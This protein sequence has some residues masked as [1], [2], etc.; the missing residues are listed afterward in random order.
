MSI[1]KGLKARARSMFRPGD[2]EAR[3]E[4]EF[5]F[6][7]ETQ[8][9]HLIREGVPPAEARRRALIAFGAVESH[10]ET[11]R[12]ERG[13]RWFD[14]LQADLRYAVGAMRRNPG[15][16]LAVSLTL[17]LGIGV[18]GI[19]F[20]YINSL[21][22]RPVPARAPE[23][24]AALFTRDTRT[25]NV[26]QFGYD[27]FI[28]FRERSGAFAGA[29]AIVAAPVNLVVPQAAGN[30]AG[31]LVWAEI[32]SE[33][34]FSVLGTRPAI[35]RFFTA[36]D[37]PQGANPFVVLS[38][39][40]WQRR[41]QGDPNVAGRTIRINGGEFVVTGVAPRGFKGMRQLGFWPEVWV[42]IGMQPLVRPGATGLLHGRG[43]GALLVVGRLQPGVDLERAQTLATDFAR[44][45]ETAYPATNTNVGVSVLPAR[46]GFENPAI[47]A[48]N[49]LVLSSALGIVG[50]LTVLLIICAN[51][52]VLQLSRTASRAREIAI[53]LSLGCSRGRLTRQLLIESLVVAAPGVALGAAA[54]RLA[55]PLE[56]YFTPKLPFQVGFGATA[57]ARVMFFTGAIAV[58]A[59]VSFGMVPAVRAGRARLIA[60][61]ASGL[62]PAR[63]EANRPSRTR[64]VLVVSQ[65]ALSVILLIAA[66]LFVRSLAMAD[67][68]NLGFEPGNR[69]MVSINVGVQGYDQSRGLQVY[70]EVLRRTR[71]LPGVVAASLAYPAPFDTNGRG[72]RLYV[73]GLANSSD[74]TVA[75]QATYVADTFIPALGVRLQSGRDFTPEDGAAAPPVMIVS[76]SLAGRMWPGK[77]A[78]GQRA[79]YGSVSGPEI[80]VVGVVGDAK[81]AML[82]DVTPRRVYL[83]L[84]QRYPDWQTLV[85]H[86]RDTPASTLSSLREVI[87]GVDPSLPPFGAMTMEQAVAN[88]FAPSRSGVAVAS[89]FGLLALLIASIGLYAVVARSVVERTGEMGVRIALGL[90]PRDVLAHLMRDGARL[91]LIGLAIGV[92]GGLALGRTMAGVLLGLSPADPITFIVVPSAVTIVIIV[93]TFVPARRASQLDAVAALKSE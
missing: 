71:L 87:A 64:S 55:S 54:M 20:G 14:D 81:F 77:S 40:A 85:V 72:V 43:G 33:D 17:G 58:A 12:D 56:S 22:F 5:Q 6:H 47:I 7:I 28:D 36:A 70:D 74:G 90:T 51:L 31:D 84:K 3:L 18:N 88:G 26:G 27:D 42:P 4:E 24:L 9:E 61:A 57:D 93:A 16:T 1:W 19:I 35:G 79:R 38:H 2:A 69:V 92:A 29:A 82:G 34:Y 68:V 83:P 63:S 78:V 30:A 25:G 23:E 76:E 86:T 39:D 66:S 13:A 65:I 59:L 75:A 53:R 67:S 50:S 41:F 45:L 32:V 37:A 21:L 11:M 48:P 60:A 8:T 46:V 91:G 62:G 15:F 73:E 44:Q 80:T 52:A 49:I 10:R 89:F